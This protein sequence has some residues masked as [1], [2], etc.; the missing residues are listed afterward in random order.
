MN[1][2]VHKLKQLHYVCLTNQRWSSLQAPPYIEVLSVVENEEFDQL[3][4][5]LVM[6]AK[7]IK[8]VQGLRLKHKL[9][10]L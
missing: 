3:R 2:A 10:F 8:H 4:P 1:E 5:E 9:Q 6:A 7:N